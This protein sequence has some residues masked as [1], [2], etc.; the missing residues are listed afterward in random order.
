MALPVTPP[1]ADG[2]LIPHT[3]ASNRRYLA[4]RGRHP[5]PT[6][7]TGRSIPRNDGWERGTGHHHL[8]CSMPLAYPGAALVRVPPHTSC[9][10]TAACPHYHWLP[11]A[12]DGTNRHEASYVQCAIGA[13]TNLDDVTSWWL[14]GGSEQWSTIYAMAPK[15]DFDKELVD[16]NKVTNVDTAG[17]TRRPLYVVCAHG[18]AQLLLSGCKN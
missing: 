7:A 12:I 11:I 18:E 13:T 15:V 14:M 1:I 5:T 2:G 4:G 8:R 16:A 10:C 6:S 9:R 3:A 17:V